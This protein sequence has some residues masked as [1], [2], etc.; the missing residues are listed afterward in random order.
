ATNEIGQVTCSDGADEST[1]RQE[2]DDHGLLP[3]WKREAILTALAV[4]LAGVLVDDIVHGQDAV[5][6]SRVVTEQDAAERGEDA[7]QVR[8]PCDW[9]LDTIEIG[10]GREG[11]TASRHDCDGVVEVFRGLRQLVWF[12]AVPPLYC[13]GM[14]DRGYDRRGERGAASAIFFY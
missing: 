12:V 8:L 4:R 9:G 10:R 13:E 7:H 3:G 14:K 1:E 5:D 2:G 11:D 6:V